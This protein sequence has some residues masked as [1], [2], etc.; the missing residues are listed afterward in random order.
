MKFNY[1]MFGSDNNWVMSDETVIVSKV[2]NK[3]KILRKGGLDRVHMKS[4]RALSKT[5]SFSCSFSKGI[6]IIKIDRS[7]L[8]KLS[9]ITEAILQFLAE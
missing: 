4:I 3:L 6:I 1:M 8:D 5:Y 9:T 7:I 2:H